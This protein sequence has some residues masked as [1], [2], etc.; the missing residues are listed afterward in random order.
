MSNTNRDY[1]I[2]YDVKNSSLVLSRPLIFYITDK[3]TSNIFV[4]LVTIVDVGNGIDQ[5]TDLE[6]ASNYA[7]TMRVIKPNNEVKSIEAIQHEP[8]SIFQFDLTEDFKDIPGKYICELTIST[9]VN[10]RQE[11]ITSDPFNYEVKRSILSNV[12]E[13][14]ETEDTTVEKLLNDLDVAR[15]KLSSQIAVERTR[16][17]N[18]AKLT[19]GSTTGDAELIDARVGINEITYSNVGSAIRGQLSVANKQINNMR[20]ILTEIKI[21]HFDIIEN[22]KA[23]SLGFP[24]G[25]TLNYYDSYIKNVNYGDTYFISTKTVE[26]IDYGVALLYDASGN[27]VKVEGKNTD[28]LPK[29]YEDYEVIIPYG[30]VKMIVVSHRDYS[31]NMEIKKAEFVTNCNYKELCDKLYIDTSET[32]SADREMSKVYSLAFKEGATLNTSYCTYYR[33][34]QEGEI[35]NVKMTTL[36]NEDYVGVLLYNGNTFVDYVDKNNSATPRT[37]NTTFTI[38]RDVNLIRMSTRTDI[39]FTLS[40]VTREV[41]NFTD[42]VNTVNNIADNTISPNFSYRID[43]TGIDVIFKCGNKDFRI[44]LAKKGGNNLFDFYKFGEIEN[45]SD[46]PS[47]EFDSVTNLGTSG[48]DWHS[49]FI[50]SAIN[51]IDGDNKSDGVSYNYYFTGGNH[52]YNNTGDGSTPT[53]RLTNLKYYINGKEVTSGTGYGSILEIR[54]TNMVQ[55]YNTT[56]SDG[57]GREIL[58]ENHTLIFDGVDW[59]TSNELIALEDIKME[60]CYGLQM[61]LIEIFKNT[62]QYIGGSNRQIFNASVESDCGTGKAT[63]LIA[64]GTSYVASMEIDTS[65][66]VGSFT[67]VPSPYLFTFNYGKSYFSLFNGNM[68][69]N[70]RYCY[71]GI[72]RF[73]S[74]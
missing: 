14:I 41:P 27:I 29:I 54:W 45:N 16:I 33:T 71:R 24:S 72:Y 68:N 17:D 28:G 55:G 32:I 69:Q 73:Y 62:I 23:Y 56:K 38:P 74:L 52:Q 6:P 3:N 5:Y 48:T 36:E 42:I 40:K 13:I 39:S 47:L 4:R 63:K 66:D 44:R 11:L 46:L 2:V 12:G 1:A 35:Y 34:V 37:I 60:R 26:N 65:Y 49:P 50:V 70:E 58:Q 43:D 30:V 15:A 8:E 21:D 51:N 31:T 25:T 57:T 61:D 18:L 64:T 67:D 7:L 10:S 59:K 9:I 53:A 19:E 22:D 20:N